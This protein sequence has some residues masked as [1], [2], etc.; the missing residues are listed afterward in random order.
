[1][2]YTT[3]EYGNVTLSA[4]EFGPGETITASVNVSNTGDRAGKEVVQLYL[5]DV[6]SRLVRP[7]KEL[8]GFAKLDLQ[9]GETRQV[10]F[11]IE[12]DALAFYDDALNQWVTE[13]GTFEI[14]I[15]GSSEDLQV[16]ARFDW[17][18]SPE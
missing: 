9:P 8:K 11:E 16:A 2:S 5:R 1:L 12:E 7:L 18:G 3:F 14:F 6:N 10:S 15:G 4:A 13:P 17:T